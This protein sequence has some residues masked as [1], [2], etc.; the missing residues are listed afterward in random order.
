M[1]AST[2]INLYETMLTGR[3]NKPGVVSPAQLAATYQQ[4]LTTETEELNLRLITS[5]L[6]DLVWNYTRP[7]NRLALATSVEQVTWQAMQQ[8]TG[9]SASGRKKLLFR[10]YQSVALSPEARQRLYTIWKDQQAPAGVTLTEDDYTSL[11]LALAVRDYPAPGILTEQL[12]RIKNPDRQKRLQFM[13]PALSGNVAERD[14][15][16]ASLASDSNRD[17]EAWVTAALGYLH[18]PLRAETSVKYLPK[19]LEL[20]E[21][22]QR[23]GDIFF[24]ESW[25]RSI[26]SS[27]QTPA[28]AQTVRQFLAERPAYNPRLKAKLLQAAD[29][30]FRASQLV[31]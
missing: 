2:Y 21:E 31:Y 8:T 4:L 5:Q 1:R 10:L 23:T 16:F 18:H 27:Y 25:L 11:A 30:T 15:F 9:K 29:N 13:M 12:A 17:R 28:V 3:Q 20:L 22:V 6:S 14:A 24:P 19:S 7:E 26:L